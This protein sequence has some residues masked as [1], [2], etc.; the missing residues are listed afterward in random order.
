MNL[1]TYDLPEEKFKLLFQGN[2][3]L[4]CALLQQHVITLNAFGFGGLAKD[5]KFLFDTFNEVLCSTS[6]DA[7]VI[8]KLKN[9]NA[10]KKRMF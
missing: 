1:D 4:L 7:R 9:P 10:I 6:E 2:S 5:P 3:D 8:Q